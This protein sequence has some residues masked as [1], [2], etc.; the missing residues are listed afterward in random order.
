MHKCKTIEDI[1]DGIEYAVII[2][3]SGPTKEALYLQSLINRFRPK[4]VFRGFHKIDEKLPETGFVFVTVIDFISEINALL[5]TGVAV[6]RIAVFLSQ[7]KK[8][9]SC[10]NVMGPAIDKIKASADGSA[11]ISFYDFHERLRA[12]P[13][14]QINRLG[15]LKLGTPDF[16]YSTLALS[17]QD[18]AEMAKLK[19][20]ITPMEQ[21]QLHARLAAMK[22]MEWAVNYAGNVFNSVKG[23]DHLIIN[24]GD[25][26]LNVGIASGDEIPLFLLAI[27]SSGKLINIDPTGFFGLDDEVRRLLAHDAFNVSVRDIAIGSSIGHVRILEV[28]DP[29]KISKGMPEI[30]TGESQRKTVDIECRTIDSLVESGDVPPPDIIK[31]DVQDYE[32]EAFKGALKT[33]EKYRPQLVVSVYR[34][35]RSIFDTVFTVV[36]LLRDYDVYFAVHSASRFETVM[37]C[38][39]RE[40]VGKT[41]CWGIGGK[42]GQVHMRLGSPIA[43]QIRHYLKKLT[44]G[45]W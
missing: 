17:D 44:F 3:D 30:I 18:R 11:W 5:N 37:T 32:A 16:Y 10:A 29:A 38:I 1:P 26:V 42:H 39:P 31:L 41:S 20:K 4:S 35:R 19:T 21:Q 9:N 34:S 28:T 25:C 22:P 27:G 40:K 43:A 45:A 8:M 12:T 2:P 7:A 6:E 15:M 36:N 14:G 23:F 13:N 33:V 24:E